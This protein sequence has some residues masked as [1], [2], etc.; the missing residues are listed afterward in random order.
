MKKTILILLAI[1]SMSCQAQQ[2]NDMKDYEKTVDTIINQIIALKSKYKQLEVI[3]DLA[4]IEKEISA[5]KFW[6]GF[7]YIR[8]KHI[9]YLSGIKETEGVDSFEEDGIELHIYFFKGDWTGSA[10][11][12]VIRFGDLNSVIFIENDK[13]G[14]YQDIKDIIESEKQQL[15]L[16]IPQQSTTEDYKKRQ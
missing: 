14:L 4:R 5:E 3:E 8:A 2:K 1:L 13:N 12:S 11:T 10:D 7:H 6:L 15:K 16:K 9:I